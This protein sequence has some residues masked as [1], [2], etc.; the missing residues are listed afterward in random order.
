MAQEDLDGNKLSIERRRGCH[1][2]GWQVAKAIAMGSF[3]FDLT[4]L[5]KRS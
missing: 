3:L 1:P 4:F 2:K 5:P